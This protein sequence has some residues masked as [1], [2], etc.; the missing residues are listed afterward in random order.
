MH[1]SSNTLR[2]KKGLGGL[3]VAMFRQW[4]PRVPVCPPSFLPAAHDLFFPLPT[5]LPSILPAALPP[6]HLLPFFPPS[7][8]RSSV[9]RRCRCCCAA[10]LLQAVSSICVHIW[11]GG[12]ASSSPSTS[13]CDGRWC[14]WSHPETQVTHFTYSL[15][16]VFL[17]ISTLSGVSVWKYEQQRLWPVCFTAFPACLLSVSLVP[18]TL[19]LVHCADPISPAAASSGASSLQMLLIVAVDSAILIAACSFPKYFTTSCI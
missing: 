10:R 12:G 19:L 15:T 1:K 17:S 3:E 4:V 16:S 9:F 2:E 11:G 7:F 18:R 13:A 14:T 6:A 8:V 5:C